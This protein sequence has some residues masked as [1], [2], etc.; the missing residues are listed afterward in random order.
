MRRVLSCTRMAISTHDMSFKTR[1]QLP[2]IQRRG[3][4]N[5]YVMQLA[6]WWWWCLERPVKVFWNKPT[7]RRWERDKWFI[8]F[9]LWRV[10][11]DVFVLCLADLVLF[12]WTQYL[13][14]QN[15]LLRQATESRLRLCE[16]LEASVAEC[17]RAKLRLRHQI[18]AER[19]RHIT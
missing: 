16:Q 9:F 17:E 13:S 12:G 2:C 11:C 19:Q 1:C 4:I 14:K 3:G 18:E 5:C 6:F 8:S 10:L 7:K 15:R